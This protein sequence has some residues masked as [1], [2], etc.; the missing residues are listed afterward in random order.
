M[1]SRL[2]NLR[3]PSIKEMYLIDYLVQKGNF[4]IQ[5][6]WKD[7]IMVHPMNDGNMG[8]LTIYQND[9]INEDRHFGSM[10]SDVQF[11]DVDQSIVLVS[12]YIDN[13]GKLFELDVWKIDFRPL[14]DF[15]NVGSLL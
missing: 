10:I 7:N 4:H 2:N 9:L 6:D 11:N 13:N 8:G 1:D 3:R 15:P 14:I 5:D 12:L